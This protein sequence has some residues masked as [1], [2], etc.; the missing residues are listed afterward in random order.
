MLK[1]ACVFSNKP[2]SWISCQKIVFNLHKAYQLLGNKFELIHFNFSDDT[3]NKNE[4]ESLAN[5]I[6][7]QQP[8]II[9]FLDHRP[10]PQQLFDFLMPLYNNQE[11]PK[12]IFHIFGDFSLHFTNWYELEKNLLKFPVEFVVASERQ[13]ILIDKMLNSSTSIIC[14][15]PVET[16]EFYFDEN[17]RRQ[18]RLS[19]NIKEQDKVYIYTGRLTRQK[20]TKTLIE[21][22]A[23]VFHENNDAHL[24][25]YGD[26]DHIGDPFVGVHEIEGEYFRYLYRYFDNLP[27]KLK[28]RIHFMGG[29]PNKELLSV[30][31]GADYLVIPSVHNDE[32]FGMSIAEAQFTG[33]PAILSDWGGLASFHHENLGEATRF[34]PVKI[35]TRSKLLAKNSLK[36]HLKDSFNEPFKQSRERLAQ[37]A[38]AKFGIEYCSR[39]I[40]DTLIAEK[41]NFKGFSAL[42]K[43]ISFEES[44]RRGLPLFVSKKGK[45]RKIYKEIYSA[46]I[47]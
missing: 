23:E 36:K 19:W 18:Q 34:I 27:E 4:L 6:F 35:G 30:Y 39:I 21:S 46:Y 25:L 1:I 15:F 7:K 5:E 31:C 33:L 12:I 2:S 16:N 41:N 17:L 38:I 43:Q 42:L 11:K 13:K 40:M 20:R 47:R 14:P 3:I 24:F 37:L 32:D 29:V 45:L 28:S 22:F 44:T 9:T 8:D 10:H 26:P